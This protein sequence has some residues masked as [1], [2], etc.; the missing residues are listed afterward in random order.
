I[1]WPDNGLDTGD[2]LIQK[3]TPISADD[4]LGTVYF[5]RLFPMGV[6]AM[7]ESVDLVKAGKAPRI[8][9]DESLATYEGRCGAENAKIDWGKPWRPIYN[10]IRGCNP[11]PGAWTT[12]DGKTLQIF[13]AKPL[14]AK[15]PKGIGGKLGEVLDVG[16]D[17]FSVVCADGRIRVTRVK[18]ADGGKVPAGDFAKSINL[19][20]GTRLG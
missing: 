6:D 17:G 2:V 14:P 5:D 18:P 15:D 10:L 13:E 9:Q 3:K 8:K 11:A 16:A 7:M 20:A 1:F 4:T 19:A 12:H